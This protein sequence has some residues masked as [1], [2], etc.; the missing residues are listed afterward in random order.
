MRLRLVWLVLLLL[1]SVW[2]ASKMSADPG[3]LMLAYGGTSVEMSLWV[4]LA[5]LVLIA[6]IVWLLRTVILA[7]FKPIK[8]STN[9]WRERSSRRSERRAKRGMIAYIEGHWQAAADLLERAANESNAPLGDFLFAAKAAHHAGKSDITDALLARAEDLD[10]V[11]RVAVSAVKS[12]I[13]VDREQWSVALN[14]LD[15]V[16][17]EALLHPVCLQLYAKIYSHQEQW[18]E[19]QKIMPA[20]IKRG[21]YNTQEIKQWQLAKC[22]G[23]LDKARKTADPLAQINRVWKQLTSA[24]RDESAILAY[25]AQ[26]LIDSGN[27]NKA[28]T[29]LK[30]F[31]RADWNGQVV[32][33]YGRCPSGDSVKQLMHAEAWLS[34]HPLDEVLLLTLGRLSLQNQLWAKAKEY[35]VSSINAKPNAAAYAELSRLYGSLG[36]WQKSSH[37]AQHALRLGQIDL[38]K[39]PQP[40]PHSLTESKA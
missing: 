6:L 35:F 33:L 12:A 18:D 4:A 13:L 39:L 38:P 5:A 27:G 15:R 8:T 25:Y 19:L 26:V 29:V 32:E 20:L 10:D 31:L 2:V 7:V 16:R 34:Q 37:Y 14:V 40:K 24:E 36:E 23:L 1:G 17:E 28:E 3:Y 9:W 21:Q 30:G 22:I 11:E